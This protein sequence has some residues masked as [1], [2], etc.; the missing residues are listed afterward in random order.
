M[1]AVNLLVA[2][3]ITMFLYIM[4]GWWL[5]RIGKISSKGS[6]ELASLLIWIVIPAVVMKSFCLEPTAERIYELK[7]STLAAVLALF[8]SIMGSRLLF[9]DRPMDHFAAAFSNAGFIGVPLVQ[10]TLGPDH[11][12]YI[13]SF[14]AVLNILQWTYGVSVITEKKMDITTN[15]FFNPLVVSTLIGVILFFT[16]L[17]SRMPDI[18]MGALS[19]LSAVNGPLAMLVLGVYIAQSD[20]KTLWRDMALYQVSGVR[21]FLIPLITMI[22]FR[23]ISLELPIATALIIAA[24]AP[25]GANIA[26]YAQLHG[27]DYVYA[28]KTVVIST[29]LSVISMPLMI[30]VATI[31]L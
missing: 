13:V 19:G 17:G 28:S 1:E 8:V 16:G 30:A 12:F 7:V 5:Y 2:Q 23:G 9:Q 29:L 10:T 25:V 20:I 21:L 18:L 14:I 15:A 4:V 3:I 22:V 26:V 6:G 27:K 24:S 11:V 31:I